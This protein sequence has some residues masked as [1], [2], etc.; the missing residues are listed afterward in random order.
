MHYNLYDEKDTF[1]LVLVLEGLVGLEVVNFSF[2]G[3]SGW[4]IDLHYCETEW[5]VLKMNWYHSV[6]IDIAPK[7]FISNSFVIFED[8]SISFKRF[9]PTVVDRMII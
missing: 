3:I 5:F 2:F 1:F 6:I 8:Y 4:G 9:L 7:Y